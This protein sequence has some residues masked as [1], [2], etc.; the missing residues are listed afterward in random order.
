MVRTLVVG[1]GHY[2]W[3]SDYYFSLRAIILRV[4]TIKFNLGF[5]PL[6]P[7]GLDLAK[8]ASSLAHEENEPCARRFERPTLPTTKRTL[9]AKIIKVL[10]L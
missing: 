4:R 8:E 1:F 3:D 6:F 2:I 7:E 10:I 9:P 5:G